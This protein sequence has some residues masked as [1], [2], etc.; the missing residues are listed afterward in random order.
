M[1]RTARVDRILPESR[2]ALLG[3]LTPGC[4]DAEH[5]P[6]PDLLLPEAPQP[7]RSSWLP[8]PS[9]AAPGDRGA[10]ER[11]DSLASGVALPLL[12]PNIPRKGSSAPKPSPGSH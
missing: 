7:L 4:D 10:L 5:K 9:R 8:G 2:S 12:L 11:G 1:T 6:C 3:Q